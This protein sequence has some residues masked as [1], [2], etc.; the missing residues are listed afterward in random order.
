[1]CQYKIVYLQDHFLAM[2]NTYPLLPELLYSKQNNQYETKQIEHLFSPITTAKEQLLKIISER[3]D[4][5]Y[6]HGIH[7]LTNA[8][9]DEKITI[10]M[11]E[12]DID[13]HE[14]SHNYVIFD[15]IKAFS[16]NF[17]MIKT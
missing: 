10:Q 9:T 2:T 11:N 14:I 13:V 5:S 17:Y 8:I 3:E 1:M 7:T 12:Y 4:Y 6:Y 15:M 16:K